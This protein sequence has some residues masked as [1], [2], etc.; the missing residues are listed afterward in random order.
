MIFYVR[1]PRETIERWIERKNVYGWSQGKKWLM[2]FKEDNK[3][4]RLRYAGVSR[5]YIMNNWEALSNPIQSLGG[6]IYYTLWALIFDILFY[7]LYTI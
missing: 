3:V 1:R 4:C 5:I 2:G 7:K 6:T